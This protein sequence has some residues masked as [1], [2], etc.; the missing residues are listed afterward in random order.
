[1]K[2]LKGILI[3]LLLTAAS[4]LFGNQIS[5][6]YQNMLDAFDR[7]Q[8]ESVERYFQDLK[9][10][11]GN[12]QYNDDKKNMYAMGYYLIG[13]LYLDKGYT[14][15]A[16]KNL[17]RALEYA[18]SDD[19]RYGI[20]VLR[21]KNYS[22][23]GQ[24]AYAAGALEWAVSI[25]GNDLEGTYFDLV[26]AYLKQEKFDTALKKANTALQKY[27]NSQ[28]LYL[29][30]AYIYY[31]KG[32]YLNEIGD[33]RK[34]LQ[35]GSASHLEIYKMIVDAYLKLSDL[36]WALTTCDDAI[37][38]F[39]NDR[40]LR[41][42]RAEIHDK[43]GDE[44][45]ALADYKKAVSIDP[46]YGYGYIYIGKYYRT[47]G[48]YQEAV[49]AYTDGIGSSEAD[50]RYY[51]YRGISYEALGE[52][53]AAEA[54]Y[55]KAVELE[56]AREYNYI[57]LGNLLFTNWEYEEAE[58]VYSDGIAHV[59][60]TT[61]LCNMRA[62]SYF[63]TERYEEALSDFTRVIEL[64]GRD[65]ENDYYLRYMT[66]VKLGNLEA[67][68][69]DITQAILHSQYPVADYFSARGGLFEDMGRSDE[70]LSDYR[71]ALR[72][73]E[74]DSEVSPD[75]YADIAGIL[76]EQGHYDEALDHYQSAIDASGPFD[77][78]D[79]YYLGQGDCYRELSQELL[80]AG[81]YGSAIVF[82]S[83]EAYFN[84]A[85]LYR[86]M[87]NPAQAVPDYEEFLSR[88]PGD[89][90]ALEGLAECSFNS[91]DARKSR[92]TFRK[93]TEL[94]PGNPIYWA[95]V[96][97][98]SFQGGDYTAAVDDLTHSLD[99]MF[100]DGMVTTWTEEM[101][102]RAYAN[103]QL[104]KYDEALKDIYILI[105]L[106]DSVYQQYQLLGN[107]YEGLGNMKKAAESYRDMAASIEKYSQDPDL[108]DL[109][110]Q[111]RE[112]ADKLDQ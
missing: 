85:E 107:A 51:Y 1:M 8:V 52:D 13:G 42:L 103:T 36:N 87:G 70:A 37:A 18:V 41:T 32:E 44:D 15:D 31:N 40:E 45:K 33:Y 93:L 95:H 71:E 30:R 3:I 4:S 29:K 58:A 6:L 64:G 74:L 11:L 34:A 14:E 49:D 23:K 12:P 83:S 109:A 77:K 101:Y 65:L 84:R 75:S 80:A 110:A 46:S 35:T 108:L 56:P 47:R 38:K 92:D 16:G 7:R 89:I 106:N 91:G 9:D 50:Y 98:I 86:A 68:L 94:K 61:E 21:A 62:R 26:D 67:A 105:G 69:S 54:D 78:L 82:G 48:D 97:R 60:E 76:Q 25:G 88:H 81:S 96:G 102:Y 43:N 27:P 66:Q 10:V 19:I 57:R 72:L 63:L 73:D 79:E 53:A 111:A 28:K 59:G 22:R 100:P 5:D 20:Y 55:R 90:A 112:A 24:Y 2:R 99:L 104:G 17:S 39:P